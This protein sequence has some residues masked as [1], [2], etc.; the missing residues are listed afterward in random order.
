M[1]LASE[2]RHV[3]H[4][5]RINRSGVIQMFVYDDMARASLSKQA[6]IT[7]RLPLGAAMPHSR[8]PDSSYPTAFLS[9]RKLLYEIL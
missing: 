4:G 1:H 7:K 2:F 6:A 5:T 9:R 8:I 3:R